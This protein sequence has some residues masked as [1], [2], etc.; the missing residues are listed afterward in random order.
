MV[1]AWDEDGAIKVDICA[2]NASSFAPKLDGSM[3]SPDEGLTPTLRQWTIDVSGKT[4]TVAE[5]MLDDLP[6]EFPR[7]DDRFMTRS[8]RHAYLV[9]GRDGQ[10]MF[11]RLVHYDMETG[12]RKIWGEDQYLLG[13][14]I[15]APRTG[16]TAEGDGYILILA[17]DQSTTLSQLMIFDAA[18]IEQG[19]I[20]RAKL[21]LRIPS[22]FHGTWVGA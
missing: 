19:P 12:S 22:G 5:K 4:N 15:F 17:Y 9:G 1:N 2:S 10:L 3:A 21:P 14:P 11:N 18:D 20:A 7:T 16:A 13:E 8:H 6:C